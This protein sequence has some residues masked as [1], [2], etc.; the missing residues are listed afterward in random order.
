MSI[1]PT[2]R[3]SGAK[4]VFLD[5]FRVARMGA[6]LGEGC[7]VYTTKER[8][9]QVLLVVRGWCDKALA[10]GKGLSAMNRR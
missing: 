2:R 3:E 1:S 10:L 5:A 8:M 4:R 9:K 6:V 7:G